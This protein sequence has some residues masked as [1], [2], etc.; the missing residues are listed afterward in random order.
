MRDFS[1]PEKAH[2]DAV[3]A[4]I[5]STFTSFG[6]V[7]I[8]TPMLERLQYL[9]GGQ[10]GENEKMLYKVLKRGLTE[11]DRCAAASLDDLCDLGLRYDLT[12]PLARY[13]ASHRGQ[14]PRTLRCIQIGPVWR[15]ERPQ[16]GRFRQFI[17]CDIDVLGE[18][19][20]LAEVE[21]IVATITALRSLGLHDLTV[22]LNDRRLLREVLTAC[23]LPATAHSDVLI[24]VDKLDKIGKTRVAHELHEKIGA[25]AADHL[26]EVLTAL[27]HESPGPATDLLGPHKRKIDE[28]VSELHRI[29]EGVRAGLS[30]DPPTLQFDPTL[31]RGMGYYTGSIFEIMLAGAPG[32]IAGGG[33]YDSMVGR[34]V[35]E[36]VP[37][38]GFSIGFERI[39]DLATVPSLNGRTKLALLYDSDVDVGSLV[40]AQHALIEDGYSVRLM[41]KPK[42]LANTLK[43]LAVEGFSG[44]VEIGEDGHLSPVHSIQ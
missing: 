21:L 13:F 1:G 6:Y 10:G 12:L 39:T 18:P 17:Q 30:I 20:Y 8:E 41:E 26:L 19:S 5:R 9:L 34:F 42:R 4:S 15:A 24:I 40:Q 16:K 43:A 38:C 3:L 22:R 31:V 2:R 37:A 44:V 25:D 27:R 35:G 32:A 7:E 33:R 28:F 36:D 11:D 29:E 14:L 23:R